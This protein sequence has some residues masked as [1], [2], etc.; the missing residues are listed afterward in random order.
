MKE[1]FDARA[2]EWGM[3]GWATTWGLMVFLN[4]EMFTNP[5]T[6]TIF[7]GLNDVFSV[8]VSDNIP[9]VIGVTFL[10][11]GVIRGCSLFVNGAWRKTPLIRMITSAVSAFFLTTLMVGFLQG[12]PN[13]GVVT[14]FWLFLADCLSAQRAAKDYLKAKLL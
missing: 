6:S 3:S 14:Y 2:M 9:Q 10:L 1:H 7:K 12:P 11:L 5:G 13:T 4:P 8:V